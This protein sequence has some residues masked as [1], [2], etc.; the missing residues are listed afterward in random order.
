MSEDLGLVDL[1]R[2]ILATLTR[3]EER[4]IRTT[5]M[6]EEVEKA[7]ESHVVGSFGTTEPPKE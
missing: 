1:L 4:Q 5:K 2:T 6:V 3:I 7:E